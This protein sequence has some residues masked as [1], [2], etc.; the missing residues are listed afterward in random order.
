MAGGR[1]RTAGGRLRTAG[2]RLRTAGG[3]LRTAGG[4][5]R[6]AGGRL[7]TAGGRLRTAGGGLRMA[8]G[9]PADGPWSLA[10]GWPKGSPS[11]F[12]VVVRWVRSGSIMAGRDSTPPGR[13]LDPG[14]AVVCLL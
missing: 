7:R 2:G 6:T 13:L 11:R 9:R 12:A 4:R 10:C 1:L 14:P 3:R 8:G 5:L